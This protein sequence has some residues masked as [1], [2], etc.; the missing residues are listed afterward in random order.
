[1][2]RYFLNTFKPLCLTAM[3]RQAAQRHGLPPFI[4]S[5]CRREPDLEHPAYPS[6]SALCRL[7]KFAPRLHPGDRVIYLTC[8]APY[9]GQ[10]SH[11]RLVAVLQVEHRFDS[12]KEAAEWY[13][14]QGLV[15]PSNCW[16]PDNPPMPYEKTCQV[17]P[18]DQWDREYRAR[19]RVCGVFL[20]CTA[21]YANYEAPPS[22]VED[23]LL[24]V[25]GRIPGTQNP[26]EITAQ[27]YQAL[28]AHAA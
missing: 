12:H 17:K 21:L 15:L 10:A 23:D 19:A 16:V 26:P 20:A 27:Q 25:F 22:V 28:M 9:G 5:S 4:D 24:A 8:K 18:Y 7:K 6:I 13:R 11:W 14:A 3:G 1:M 2:S